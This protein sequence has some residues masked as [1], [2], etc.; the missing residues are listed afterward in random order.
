VFR[1]ICEV[2]TFWVDLD[3]TV[4]NG[5][6]YWLALNPGQDT[7]LLWLA[8]AVANSSF[9]EAFYDHRF[10]NK[11][12]AGRRRFMTQY[13][14]QFPLPGPSTEKS[15]RLVDLAKRVYDLTPAGLT[16]DLESQADSL[17]WEAFGVSVEEACR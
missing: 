9:I 16:R 10:H 7:D 14:E 11:L 17:V 13:V 5:D 1:D 2:P 15:R 12:Y 6:C 4:V 8:V 3:G